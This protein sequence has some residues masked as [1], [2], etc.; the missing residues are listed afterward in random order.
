MCCP[1]YEIWGFH[2]GKNFICGYI[3]AN[4]LVDAIAVI[5]LCL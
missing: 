3:I 5:F 1:A 2:N 4:S